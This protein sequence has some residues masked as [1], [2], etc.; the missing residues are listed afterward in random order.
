MKLKYYA[1]VPDVREAIDHWKSLFELVEIKSPEEQKHSY[2][3][4]YGQIG[5]HMWAAEGLRDH[6]PLILRFDDSEKDLFLKAVKNIEA[7]DEVS[8]LRKLQPYF[9]GTTLLRFKDKM[10]YVWVIEINTEAIQ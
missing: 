1:T 5:V 2:V 6:N 8:I 4:L 7:S 9:W 3:Q 10:G